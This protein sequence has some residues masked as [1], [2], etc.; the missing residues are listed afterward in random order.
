MPITVLNI[1][2]VVNKTDETQLTSWMLRMGTVYINSS[3]SAVYQVVRMIMENKEWEGGWAR[4]G[5]VVLYGGVRKCFS[6]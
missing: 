4:G 3:S 5:V 2:D 1:R 6:R